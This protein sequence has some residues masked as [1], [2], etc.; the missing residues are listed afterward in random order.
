MFYVCIEATFHFIANNRR[1]VDFDDSPLSIHS[2]PITSPLQL[3][4]SPARHP[5]PSQS[6]QAEKDVNLDVATPGGLQTALSL[7]SLNHC[8]EDS[9]M[10][11]MS[12]STDPPSRTHRTQV[13]DSIRTSTN[14]QHRVLRMQPQNRLSIRSRVPI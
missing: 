4:V 13:L 11:V 8:G 10:S 6:W 14:A 3:T 7:L 1:H 12:V 9:H 2:S 5:I